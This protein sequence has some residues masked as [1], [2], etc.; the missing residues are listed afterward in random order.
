MEK[1]AREIKKL[2]KTLEKRNMKVEQKDMST[3][4]NLDI[5]GREAAKGNLTEKGVGRKK[6]YS[7]GVIVELRREQFLRNL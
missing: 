3:Q 4:T 6:K 1:V 7:A 5:K 2:R